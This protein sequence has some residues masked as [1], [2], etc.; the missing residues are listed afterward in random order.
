MADIGKNKNVAVCA[1]RGLTDA[2]YFTPQQLLEMEEVIAGK[3]IE[4]KSEKQWLTIREACLHAKISRT[5]LWKLYRSGCLMSYMLGGR[6]L[7]ERGELDSVILA[8]QTKFNIRPAK[9]RRNR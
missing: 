7:I 4:K 3:E 6:R 5:M 8:G 2:G 9:A 1:L